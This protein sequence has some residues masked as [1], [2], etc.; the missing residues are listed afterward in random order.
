MLL[1][2]YFIL[3][4]LIRR[5]DSDKDLELKTRQKETINCRIMVYGPSLN[6]D[7]L[8]SLAHILTS[9]LDPNFWNTKCGSGTDALQVP[10]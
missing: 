6:S 10:F 5:R 4:F 8:C 3:F 9:L 2:S 1:F 7:M